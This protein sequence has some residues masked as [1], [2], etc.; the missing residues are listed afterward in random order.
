M[1][2]ELYSLEESA[3][4]AGVSTET[5]EQYSK[6]GL[7][8]GVEEA[9]TKCYRVTDLKTLFHAEVKRSPDESKLEEAI[10]ADEII[11]EKDQAVNLD[12]VIDLKNELPEE[13]KS[14][15]FGSTDLMET[16]QALR[17]QIQML[18]EERDW[19]RTRLEQLE[20]RSER[21]QMLLMSESETIRSLI[22]KQPIKRWSF[23][24]PWF[25]K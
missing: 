1:E 25:D 14:Q 2:R 10:L 4:F 21:E 3:A 24:L 12:R 8:E 11:V 6:F 7:L 13:F 22:G 16:N 23:S 20:A 18:R 9:G 15:S 17:E 19:L 5:I